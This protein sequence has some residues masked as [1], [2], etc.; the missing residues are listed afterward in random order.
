MEKNFSFVKKKKL[1]FFFFI[2]KKKKV[3]KIQFTKKRISRNNKKIFCLLS[4]RKQK[5]NTLIRIFPKIC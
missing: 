3:T 5:E 4:N 1:L 2:F